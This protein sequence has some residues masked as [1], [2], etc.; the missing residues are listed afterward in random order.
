MPTALWLP[1]GRAS[2]LSMP[3]TQVIRPRP[4]R[5]RLRERVAPSAGLGPRRVPRS[6]R[7][8]RP[9]A[10]LRARRVLFSVAS[11]CCETWRHPCWLRCAPI[12]PAPAPEASTR[13]PR[14]HWHTTRCAIRASASPTRSTRRSA[15]PGLGLRLAVDATLP[16]GDRNAFA[17][18]RSFVVMP[19]ATF[20]FQHRALRLSAELGARL[21]QGGRF[22]RRH[23]GK[24]G[25]RGNRRGRRT[26]PAR[27]ADAQRGG[28]R[29]ASSVRAIAAARRVRWSARPGS[30]PLSGCSACTP[31]SAALARGRLSLAAGSGIPLSSE[32]RESS[33]GPQTSYF[34]GMTT[35][36]F[37]SLLVLRFAPAER[38]RRH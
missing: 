18:E 25:L 13:N 8:R 5:F 15:V 24:S 19:N 32:T 11:V 3:D 23:P 22:C 10:R 35:P 36:D 29:T 6:R 20:G 38:Q 26:A 30:F 7:P 37:R 16:L 14:R 17:N 9:S 12:N 27:L 33:S 4:G 21:R 28:V 1:A 34:L 31:R 2:F